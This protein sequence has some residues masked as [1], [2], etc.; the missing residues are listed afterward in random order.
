MQARTADWKVPV[1]AISALK[2]IGVVEVL[3][4]MEKFFVHATTAGLLS[5]RR[6]SQ[7]SEALMQALHEGL[8]DKFLRNEK[9]ADEV[10]R[11][12]RKVAMGQLTP[13]L[14]ARALID[15]FT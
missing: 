9:N 5:S 4:Q 15:Q 11:V 12:R 10:E 7:A 3:E 1:L 2:D 6:E 14:A 8:L 13:A